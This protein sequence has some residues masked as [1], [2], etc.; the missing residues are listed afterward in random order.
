MHRCFVVT[1]VAGEAL[2]DGVGDVLLVCGAVAKGN[3]FLAVG[4][5]VGSGGDVA[6][7]V[8]VYSW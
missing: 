3:Y 1:L 6:V 5:I 2:S 4:H 8:C 7:L